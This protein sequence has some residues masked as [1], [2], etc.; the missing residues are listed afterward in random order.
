MGT[1]QGRRHVVRAFPAVRPASR[2]RTAD[3][4]A[5]VGVSRARALLARLRVRGGRDRR[6]H[7]D[8]GHEA[9][10]DVGSCI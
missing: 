1:P 10:D 8:A 2:S 7:D 4:G 9:L 3:N 6:E 5:G